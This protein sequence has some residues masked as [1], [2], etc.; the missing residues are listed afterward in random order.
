MKISILGLLGIVLITL[1]LAEIGVVAT[2]SWVWVLTP[3]WIG[4]A[5]MGFMLITAIIG[6]TFISKWK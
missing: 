2:W 5:I 6:I 1:K 4:F 3:F